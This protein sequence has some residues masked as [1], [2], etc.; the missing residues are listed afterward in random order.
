MII[1]K[2]YNK[3]YSA[4]KTKCPFGLFL[5]AQIRL[6]KKDFSKK[7]SSVVQIMGYVPVGC[8]WKNLTFTEHLILSIGVLVCSGCYTKIP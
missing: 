1:I 6:F 4:I 7:G 2:T 3:Y 8:K 5:L